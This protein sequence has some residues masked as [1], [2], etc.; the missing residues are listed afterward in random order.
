VGK[1]KKISFEM[2]SARI[3]SIE[4]WQRVLVEWKLKKTTQDISSLEFHVLRG[5][6]PEDLKQLTP[7]GGLT[8]QDKPEFIDYTAQ[9]KDLS[10]VYYYKVEAREMSGNSVVQTFSTEPFTWDGD[11]DLTGIYVIDEHIFAHK[12]VYG[13]PCMI[14]KKK[15]EGVKDDGPGGNFDPILK[16]NIRSN[17]KKTVGTPYIGGYYPPIDAWVHFDPDP[18]LV[19]IPEWGEKQSRQSDIQFTNY[20]LLTPG[21]IIVEV[22]Q[23]RYWRVVNVRMA[24]KNRVVTI[25]VARVDEIN[26][27]DIEYTLELPEERRK[28]MIEELRERVNTPEF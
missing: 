8:Y 19:Q 20:P 17:D 2:A 7:P 21:D 23:Y 6:S 3:L 5:E 26:R 25:Q 14:F 18:K 27:S 13:Q 4:H 1:L 9:L 24:E 16:K 15:K 28:A 10:K 12:Y 22:K 11:L